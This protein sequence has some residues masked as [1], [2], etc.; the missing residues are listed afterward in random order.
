MTVFLTAIVVVDIPGI[1]IGN[2][3]AESTNTSSVS[4]LI[5]KGDSLFNQGR[6]EEAVWLK[7]TKVNYY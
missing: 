2:A 6:Y 5:T 3:E 7:N 1:Q 4:K